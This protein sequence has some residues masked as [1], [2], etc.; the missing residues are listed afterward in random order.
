MKYEAWKHTS[1]PL[2]LAVCDDLADVFGKEGFR[3]ARSVPKL[4]GKQKDCKLQ[5]LFASSHSNVAGKYV[6]FEICPYIFV[7]NPAQMLPDRRGKDIISYDLTEESEEAKEKQC[8][9]LKFPF[10][11]SKRICYDNINQPHNAKPCI[12]YRSIVNLS[13]IDTQKFEQL[14]IYMRE[15]FVIPFQKL[16]AS[17]LL[18]RRIAAFSEQKDSFTVMH[19]DSGL[20]L[21]SKRNADA[22]FDT[23]LKNRR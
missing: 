1:R 15:K 11:K 19:T 22:T 5:I 8:I 14:V 23:V 4:T 17:D 20:A 7:T 21:E 9:I 3:Y 12:Q 6:C 13:E 2:F 10:G 16:A 18:Q